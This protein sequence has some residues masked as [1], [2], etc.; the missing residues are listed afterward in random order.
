MRRALELIRLRLSRMWLVMLLLS[1]I[2]TGFAAFWW[3]FD[4]MEISDDERGAYD[5]G[6]KAFTLPKRDA[7]KFVQEKTGLG[8]SGRSEDVVVV[9]LDDV[10]MTQVSEQE[11][12]RQ[13]YGANLPF[14]RVVWADLV[15]YLSRA[16]AKAIVFDMVMNEQSS[17]GT[18]DLAFANALK[19]IQTP[20]ILGFNTSPT[21]NPLPRVE[22]T[23][24]RPVGPMPT[25]PEKVVPEGEFPED[26]TPEEQLALAKAAGENRILWAA[27]AYSVPVTL[28]DLEMPRFPVEIERNADG[29]PTGKEFANY[30]MPSLPRVLETTDG[31]GAVSSEEDEDGKLRRTG[32]VFSDGNNTYATSPVVVLAQLEKA[33]EVQVEPGKLTIGSRTVRINNDGTAEIHYGGRL[34]DR[35]RMIPLVDVVSRFHFCNA[36]IGKTDAVKADC[37]GGVIEQDPQGSVFK[38]KIVV[39]GGVAVGTGDSKATPLEQATPGLVKTAATI[40]NM[41]KDQFILAAPFWV[42]LLFSFLV[43]LFSVGLVLVVRNTFVD[44][45]WPVLL[46]VGFFTITGSFLVATRIHVL[47]ALPGLAG[48]VASILATSWERLFARK[49]RDRLKELFQNYMES[50]LVEL[51]VEQKQLP[52]LEGE[53]LHV[54]A[55]FSDIKGFSTF[56]EKLKDEPRSLMRLLNRYLSV[57]TPELTAE[58]A[59]IDKYIGDAVVALFGA[60]VTHSDHALR[61]CRGALKVQKAI[62]ALRED[63]RGEGL[64]DVYTRVGLNTGTM[65]VGNIGSA[66]LLDYTAIGDE[67]NL[68]ARLE[69]ANKNYGTLIMMGPG[70]YEAVKEH[71]EARELDHVRVAGKQNAVTVYELLAMRGELHHDKLKVVD[72]YGQALLAYRARRFTDAKIKLGQ[73]LQVDESDG[74]SRR[75]LSLCTEYELHPPPEGWDAVSGL[76]K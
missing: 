7:I 45:G 39:V 22:P 62:A 16:G 49:E 11:F 5:D 28:K 53:N 41:I 1:V 19:E 27:K 10:T 59:C 51:M 67:M 33:T 29:E 8:K 37:P 68:A 66:Q 52:S 36:R 15:T 71:V 6:L 69:G 65:M 24:V 58:G 73:A 60:P 20:V 2:A 18:G 26:P 46:Y 17:D 50:D 30:P 38:D 4:V 74:P 42:S 21:A 57:V 44:I 35:F 14:D 64:P 48:T 31:F 72:L 32:F 9:A 47:S 12:L 75:L 25:P 13:R 61:A 23:M 43:A 40:D 70:T 55:F 63:F 76:E 34:H 56:S 54:T 3:E